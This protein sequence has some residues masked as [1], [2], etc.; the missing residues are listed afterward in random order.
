MI[1]AAL[2]RTLSHMARNEINGNAATKINNNET[3]ARINVCGNAT[4]THHCRRKN[5]C[6]SAARDR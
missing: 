4:S 5:A 1:R 6:G 3:N 2:P